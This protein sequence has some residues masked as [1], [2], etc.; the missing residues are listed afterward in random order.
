MH[1]VL[2]LGAGKIGALISGLLAESGSYRVQLADVDG[3]AAEAVVRA[4][5]GGH[6]SALRPGCD[7]CGRP[8][9]T[10][11]RSPGGCGDLEPPLLLQRRG[12]RGCAQGRHALLRPDRGCRS[13]ARGAYHRRSARRR[14]SCP[15]C[16]LAPGF[17]SIAA[18]ELITHFDDAA[19]GEAA[20]RRPAP[21]P[22]QRAQVLPHLVDRRPHQ[23][24]RQS[25]PGRSCD[26]RLVEVAPLEGLEEIEIDGTLYE[27]FNTSGG[28]GLA[29]RDATAR[30]SSR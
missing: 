20:R 29:R 12:R 15:Q 5:G 26:G 8:R 13:D 24:V 17:I 23:R 4:H 11:G 14:P 30:T 10:A 1:R 2:I 25:L 27:A 16:G 7:R 19:R 22:E 28:L 18:A 21:A 6:L 3:A 9:E